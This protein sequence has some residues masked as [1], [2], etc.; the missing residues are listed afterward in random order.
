MAT[1]GADAAPVAVEMANLL[2]A[3]EDCSRPKKE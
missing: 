2:P 1:K 3:L